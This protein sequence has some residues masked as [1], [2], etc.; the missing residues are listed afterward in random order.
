MRWSELKPGDVLV[1]KRSPRVYLV[2]EPEEGEIRLFDIVNGK[3]MDTTRSD[4]EV[5]PYHYEAVV[6]PP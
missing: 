4:R 5:N 1:S 2:L 3:M 6:R